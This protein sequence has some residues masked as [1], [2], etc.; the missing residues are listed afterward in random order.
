[1]GLFSK[2]IKTLDDLFVH[3][4]QDIYYAE[5][6]IVKNLPTMAEEATEPELKAAFQHH[7]TETREHVRRLEQVFEMHGQSVKGV[8]CQA[9]DGIIA[10]AKDIISDCDDP[11]VRDAAMLSAA[12]AVEHYEI[13]RYGSLI[14]YARQLGRTD[15]AA[16]LEQTL[17]EEKSADQKLTDIAGMSVNQHAAA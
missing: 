11:E 2:P 9:M 7:L 17:K 6:Q 10:E 13:T 5:N 4:L 1:M 8:T 12:Q 16:V 3:T 14:A 15:C